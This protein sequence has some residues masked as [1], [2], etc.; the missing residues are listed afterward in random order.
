MPDPV[1]RPGGWP[2]ASWFPTGAPQATDRH[3]FDASELELTVT[4]SPDRV[5]LGQP[6]NVEWTLTNRSGVDLIAPNDVSLEALFAT[7]T[8]TDGEGHD[9]PMRP[10]VIICDR[11]KLEA[12]G[13]GQSVSASSRVFWSSAGF[14]FERPGRY[15]VTVSVDWSAQGVAVN[16][17]SGVDVF[18]EFPTTDIDNHAAGLV[19]HP[20]V[21]KWVALGGGAYHLPEAVRRLQ[22][23][24]DASAARDAGGAPRLLE[25]FDGLM[26]ERSRVARLFPGMVEAARGGRPAARTAAARRRPARRKR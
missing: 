13:P 14:A 2:F 8:I 22:E 23:L 24:S 9:K 6:V 1:I 7:M 17:H 4:C 11:A 26:P 19:L 15:H 16:V 10:F 21:G 3:E 12:L 5:S 25:G 18:I 20:E